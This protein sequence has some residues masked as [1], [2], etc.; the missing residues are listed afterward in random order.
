VGWIVFVLAAIPALAQSGAIEGIVVDAVTKAPIAGAE[1]KLY[2]GDKAVQ[3]AGSDGQGLFRI[4][5]VPDGQ[6]RV[7]IAH[8]DHLPLAWD[9]T[10]AQTFV[11][12]AATA[13][14]RLSAE[15]V[16][17]GQIAG[18]VMSPTRDSMKGVPVGLR[19]P[20][21]EQWS[22]IT[23]SGDE[24]RFHFRQLEPGTWILAAMPSFRISLADP[25]NNP[26]PVPGPAEEEGQRVGWATTFFPGSLDLAGAERIVLRPGAILEGYDVKLRTAA[27]RRLS[28][29][30]IDPMAIPHRERG[31]ADR[32]GEQ[33]REW[34]P[35]DDRSRRPFRVRFG[36][37]GD[38]R[39]F[40][41]LAQSGRTWK[42]YADVHVSRSDIAG[43]EVRLTA[44]FSVKGFVE[45]EEPRDK[46][47]NRKVTGVYLI[48]QG[49]SADVQVAAFHEQDGSFVL[50]NVY[51]GR[52]RVLP[53]GLVPGHYVESVWYGEQEVTTRAIDVMNPPLPLKVV[54]RSGAGRA[55]GTVERGE[56]AWVVL[57][58]QKRRCATPISLFGRRDARLMESSRST[59]CAQAAITRSR[60]TASAKRCSR[61]WNSCGRSYRAR[62]VSKCGM[63]RRRISTWS[64]RCGRTT[65]LGMSELRSDW[66]AEAPAPPRSASTMSKVHG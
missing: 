22:Q 13:E 28:G 20:W 63:G 7:A 1:V 24:G 23:T 44:P 42:G 2:S 19:R 26:K 59:I 27:L 53:V 33:G 40:A 18:R 17:L 5:G 38:W 14:V 43:I 3:S 60:S 49:A 62:F 47:G 8:S 31:V 55:A 16:P 10:A 34:R 61:M 57:V 39:I 52:Y 32:S 37:G 41:Q 6:Y 9:H 35:Q 15:L 12:S 29:V 54:Y 46:D 64:R 4:A 25:K 58:P 48:P 21:D 11:I 51:R 30:V 66:Q 36:Q 65:D 45:R 50:K 56:G